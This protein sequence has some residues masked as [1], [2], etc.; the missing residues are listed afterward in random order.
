MEPG[1][2]AFITTILAVTLL[3]LLPFLTVM[4]TAFTK[5]SIV[6]ML[7]R[8]ALGVQMA[9]SALV[10]NSI[11]LTLTA[12]ILVPVG[13][14]I[15][16]EIQER[17][18]QLDEWEDAIEIYNIFSGSFSEYIKKHTKEEELDFFVDAAKMIWPEN[19]HNYAHSENIFLLLP[20]HVTSEITR[21]FE[22][23]FLLFLPF[24]VI[25][26]VVSNVLLAMGAMMVPP[27]LISLPIKILLFVAVDGWPRLLHALI[28]SYA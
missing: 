1:N 18:T 13:D 12:F 6:L 2:P 14:Q 25:D 7:L 26:M 24:V 20:A 4:A 19:L 17:G 28:L 22:I 21:A 15:L 11:A 5:I 3:S 27:M 10:I 9:P 23:A 16:L 8:N